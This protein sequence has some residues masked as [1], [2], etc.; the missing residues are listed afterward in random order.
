MNMEPGTGGI[1]FYKKDLLKELKPDWQ[2][3]T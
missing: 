3:P 1:N 2:L